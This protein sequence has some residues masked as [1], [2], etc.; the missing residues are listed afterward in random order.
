[1]KSTRKTE[2]TTVKMYNLINS[3]KKNTYEHFF[4]SLKESD[5]ISADDVIELRLRWISSYETIKPRH[6]GLGL[7]GRRKT[8]GGVGQSDVLGPTATSDKAD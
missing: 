1:M 7:R 2:I 5:T 8:T 3:F 6:V 4:F